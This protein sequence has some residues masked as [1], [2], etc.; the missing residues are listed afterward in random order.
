[1]RR[2]CLTAALGLSYGQMPGLRAAGSA[3]RATNSARFRASRIPQRCARHEH[4][5]MTKAV[6]LRCSLEATVAGV[7]PGKPPAPPRSQPID[8]S[9][10]PAGH[11]G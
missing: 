7:R 10:M 1:M 6:G 2:H 3:N 8:R 9:P 4:H 5:E 11:G